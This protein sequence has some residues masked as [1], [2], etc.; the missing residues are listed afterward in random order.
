MPIG[1]VL[2]TVAPALEREVYSKLSK[3]PEIIEAVL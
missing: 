3:V 1:F 2:M